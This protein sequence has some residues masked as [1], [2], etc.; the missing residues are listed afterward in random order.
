M[1]GLQPPPQISPLH[2]IQYM[3]TYI[4][5][6]LHY[7]ERKTL[8]LTFCSFLGTCG[9]TCTTFV[10]LLT[11]RS[12]IPTNFGICKFLNN[13]FLCSDVLQP[14]SHPFLIPMHRPHTLMWYFTPS[15]HHHLN[16]STC[17]A[18]GRR[19]EGMETERDQLLRYNC[20]AALVQQDVLLGT[21]SQ[22]LSLASQRK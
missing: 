5:L 13:S 4:W 15:P 21:D 12:H 6:Y 10:H 16:T 17:I 8:L 19:V 11:L 14:I 1:S 3:Y 7:H 18:P 20:P 9:S 2:I 22:S